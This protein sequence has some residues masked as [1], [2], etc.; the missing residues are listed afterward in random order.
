[1][2]RVIGLPSAPDRVGLARL[3]TGAPAAADSATLTD[4]NIS[5]TVSATTGGALACAGLETVL[6]AVEL[7]GGTNPQVT[8]DLLFRDVDAA[9][10]SRWRRAGQPVALTASFQEVYV[11]GSTVFPRLD[12]VSGSPTSVTILVKPG[13]YQTRGGF[14]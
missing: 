3:V 8:L 2:A 6:L 5:P 9:D 11:Y 10:G 7:A 12:T 13:R 4:A 14:R 1:M